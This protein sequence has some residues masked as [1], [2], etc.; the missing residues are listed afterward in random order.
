VVVKPRR[1][2]TEERAKER[3]RKQAVYS[4]SK[5]FRKWALQE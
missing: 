3:Y 2:K 5:L 4:T 1:T